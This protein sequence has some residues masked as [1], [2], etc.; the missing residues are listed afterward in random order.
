MR[1][2]ARQGGFI[3]GLIFRVHG[4]GSGEPRRPER[5]EKL[6]PANHAFAQRAHAHLP[7]AGALFPIEILD[8]DHFD[9]RKSHVQRNPPSA[10]PAL[11]GGMARV[12][13]V[14]NPVWIHIADDAAN[15]PHR[16]SDIIA[17]VVVIS[18]CDAVLFSHHDQSGDVTPHLGNS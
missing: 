15:V 2:I 7:L 12:E 17:G 4:D 16:R 3:R 13:I 6:R 18:G 11:R 10:F 14:A 1:E 9:A 5:S 8:G